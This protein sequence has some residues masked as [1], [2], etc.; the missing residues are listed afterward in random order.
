M[1]VSTHAVLADALA[2]G[3]VKMAQIVLLIFDE[4]KELLVLVVHAER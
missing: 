4:G 1:V 2:H 3:F